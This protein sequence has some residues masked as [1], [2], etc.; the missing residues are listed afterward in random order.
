MTEIHNPFTAK[1]QV[2]QDDD[3]KQE[4]V[5]SIEDPKPLMKRDRNRPPAIDADQTLEDSSALLESIQSHTPVIANKTPEKP[6]EDKNTE[7]DNENTVSP[8]VNETDVK[9]HVTRDNVIPKQALE[10]TKEEVAIP[11][12][13]ENDDVIVKSDFFSDSSNAKFKTPQVKEEIAEIP[14]QEE[15]KEVTA[16]SKISKNFSK[17]K[18]QAASLSE[19]AKRIQQKNKAE[20]ALQVI[21]EEEKLS[22]EKESAKSE[23]KTRISNLFT[24]VILPI[25]ASLTI[26]AGSALIYFGFQDV[27]TASF[28]ETTAKVVSLENVSESKTRSAGCEITYIYTGKFDKYQGVAYMSELCDTQDIKEGSTI[29]AHYRQDHELDASLNAPDPNA[30]WLLVYG[31]ASLAGIGLVI[32]SVLFVSSIRRTRKPKKS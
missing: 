22:A 8:R 16:L 2:N 21:Q 1:K 19:S 25:T 3:K 4:K 9:K 28:T 11:D 27:S 23:R 5:E 32:G 30:G 7:T 6:V 20:L 12:F 26:L 29:L 17:P 18:K 14:V 10:E 13:F 31:G 24:K 15:V